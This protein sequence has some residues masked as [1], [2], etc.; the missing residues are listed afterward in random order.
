MEVGKGGQRRA[1][2]LACDSVVA[3]AVPELLVSLAVAVPYSVASHESASAAA[4][5]A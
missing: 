1:A 2:A 3:L 4:P 5:D